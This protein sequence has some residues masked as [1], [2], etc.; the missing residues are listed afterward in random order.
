MPRMTRVSRSLLALLFL[1]GAITFAPP[2]ATASPIA[3]LL[4]LHPRASKAEDS[5]VIVQ[6][7]NKGL[8]FQDLNVDGHTYTVRP[9]CWLT[10]KAPAGTAVYA[11]S[12][13]FGHRKGDLLFA[14]TPQMKNATVTLQ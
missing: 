11:A 4:H 5:R 8:E 7:Y 10:I 2:V 14:L 1:A 13:G 3:K 9:H 12:T 6:V